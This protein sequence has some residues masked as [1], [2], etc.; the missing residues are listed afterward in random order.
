METSTPYD[1]T[2]PISSQ[3][4]IISIATQF[5]AAQLAAETRL[6]DEAIIAKALHLTEL[7]LNQINEGFSE[8][9][10]PNRASDV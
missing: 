4:L 5:V 3:A 8:P 2:R 10:R 7:L 9:T 6:K 1:R